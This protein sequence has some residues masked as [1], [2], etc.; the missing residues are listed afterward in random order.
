[1]C[2]CWALTQCAS[3][4]CIRHYGMAK[5]GH[6]K[7]FRSGKADQRGGVAAP[8]VRMHRLRQEQL[9]LVMVITVITRTTVAS[10]HGYLC[11][12]PRLKGPGNE[13]NTT[14]D[15]SIYR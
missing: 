1:M 4:R 13:A 3:S 11:S 15:S 2:I 14:A 6:R 9:L 7:K 8:L 10:Y 5:Q 12:Y